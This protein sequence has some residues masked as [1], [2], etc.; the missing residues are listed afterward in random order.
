MPIKTN[1]K[2]MAP[3]RQQYKREITLLSHGYNN[4]TAWPDG[5]LT[6]F[7]WDSAI[8]Q[9]LIDN[10]RKLS[11][12]ELV[13]GLLRHCCD[14]NSGNI[15]D[16]VTD[17]INVVLLVS[18]ALSTDGVVVYTSQCPFCGFKKQEQIKVPD[19]LEKLGEKSADYPGFDLIKLPVVEDAVKIRPLLVRDEKLILTR[20]EEKKKV[21]PDGELR[22]IMRVVSINDTKAETLD[23]L[24]TWFRAL[25]AKDAKFL[26]DEG[27]R[28][29]P[30]LNTN[31]PHVCDEPDC[32]KK[33]TYPLNF[34][35]DFF[36]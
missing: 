18:R 33:F 11:K 31:I 29:T 12:P 2:S 17:E 35:Q 25:H 34:D 22:T 32:G 30:H 20:E 3:R 4:P 15:D 23:E 7:P 16:F 14:L 13:Y 26:E 27:R 24:V 5:K 10:V 1:L 21:V 6:V 8:D 36:R 19:E 28:L 9:W